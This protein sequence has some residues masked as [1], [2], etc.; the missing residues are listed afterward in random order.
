MWALVINPTAG[1]GK[2]DL[3]EDD[4]RY[5][6]PAGLERQQ[7]V[8]RNDYHRCLCPR[9][10]SV[11]C[12]HLKWTAETTDRGGVA[13]IHAGRC[14]LLVLKIRFVFDLRPTACWAR[15]ERITGHGTRAGKST[16]KRRQN[17]V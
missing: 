1:S 13:P 5:H 2:A 17:N 12:D 16:G 9:A 6:S 7:G 11:A 8:A 14:G 4:C 10:R 3:G 15:Y